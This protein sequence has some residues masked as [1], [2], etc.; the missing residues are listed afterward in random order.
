MI[1]LDYYANKSYQNYQELNGNDPGGFV[2][3]IIPRP[4]YLPST[5]TV[6]KPAKP[7]G[8]RRRELAND[9]YS[10]YGYT[11]DKAADHIAGINFEKAVQ[12]SAYKD[13]SDYE[14]AYFIKQ[15]NQIGYELA[16]QETIENR[17]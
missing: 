7:I 16:K 8:D 4:G 14:K 6:Q 2:V 10:K 13:L 17:K 11:G 9:F 12:T 15:I 1:I 3:P 5:K